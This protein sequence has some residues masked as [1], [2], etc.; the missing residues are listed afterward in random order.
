MAAL[1]EVLRFKI[2]RSC[3]LNQ[4]YLMWR[5][6]FGVMEGWLFTGEKDTDLDVKETSSYQQIDRRHTIAKAKPATILITV[7]TGNLT[8]SQAMAISAVHTSP[9]VRRVYKLDSGRPSEKVYVLPGSF[10]I[11]NETEARF[12][13]EFKVEVEHVNALVN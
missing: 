11:K 2:D 9:E 3:Y 10:Q 6:R 13:I 8:E 5:N 4:I 12:S 7:R 1:T